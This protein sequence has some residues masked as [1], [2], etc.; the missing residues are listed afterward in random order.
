M[1]N[2]SPPGHVTVPASSPNTEEAV[3]TCG[4]FDRTEPNVNS[5]A[6]HRYVVCS[7]YTLALRERR[8]LLTVRWPV[9][10]RMSPMST[11]GGE[12]PGD[13]D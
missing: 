10:V 7:L 6:N 1:H 9:G 8:R 5:H 12:R 4:C 13:W 2:L 11:K 3:K